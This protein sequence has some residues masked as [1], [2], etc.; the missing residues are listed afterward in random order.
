MW[1]KRHHSQP[2]IQHQE[3]RAWYTRELGQHLSDVERRELDNVLPNLFG[4]H[5]LQ[6]GSPV[7]D[8]LYE[9]SRVSHK[10][11]VE[12]LD[13][14]A[15]GSRRPSLWGEADAL[16]VVTDSVDV[17]ILP[18]T[19]E[20]APDP[21][22]VLREADRVLVPEG[23]IVILGFNPWSMWGI[24]RLLTGRWAGA[25]WSGQ[26][27]SVMRVRDWLSLLGFETKRVHCYFFRPPLQPVG[28][29]RRLVFM[30]ALGERWCPIFGAGY[31]IVAKKRVI[32][33]T[34][35]K[36]RWQ[37]KRRLVN[38]GVVK[39]TINLNP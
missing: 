9:T 32:T 39:P 34:P 15:N 38:T 19:L 30:E 11:Y 5:L 14:D 12:S 27:R 18:H 29:M 8:V 33:V 22:Q 31:L 36:P 6:I 25:P 23:H 20:F 2:E 3:L 26:F 13:P 4:Y 24:R 35:V 37:P 16:P 28:L 10:V 17:V 1:R 7:N 21:H